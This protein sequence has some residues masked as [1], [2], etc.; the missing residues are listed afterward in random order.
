MFHRTVTFGHPDGLHAGPAWELVDAVAQA[1]LPVRIGRPGEVP[2]PAWD[3][4]EVMRL[5][6]RYGDRV[7]ISAEGTDAERVL[8][9]LVVLLADNR[10]PSA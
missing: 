4:L 2:V 3:I 8:D 6:V 9:E 1:N 7:V 5:G 10:P